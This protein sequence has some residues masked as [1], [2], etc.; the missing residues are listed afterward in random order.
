VAPSFAAQQT[1]E[2]LFIGLFSLALPLAESIVSCTRTLLR[3]AA[4]PM[5]GA[6]ER[7]V[8]RFALFCLP[9]QCLVPL[10][11]FLL[12]SAASGERSARCYSALSRF[13]V[14][15]VAEREHARA[16]ASRCAAGGRRAFH[17]RG[18]VRCLGPPATG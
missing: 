11:H 7:G 5:K 4:W 3:C 15:F 18:A 12:A 9:V 14:R 8:Q 13:V 1:Q 2:L 16:A 6:N 17:L 10:S